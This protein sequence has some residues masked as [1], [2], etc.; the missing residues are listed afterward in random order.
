MRNLSVEDLSQHIEL[1]RP[2]PGF[3]YQITKSDVKTLVALDFPASWM[4]EID[5]PEFGKIIPTDHLLATIDEDYRNVGW[6][7]GE[8][9]SYKNDSYAGLICCYSCY[10]TLSSVIDLIPEEAQFSFFTVESDHPD[11]IT[12]GTVRIYLTLD[13][14]NAMSAEQF[15]AIR[16]LQG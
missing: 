15:K 3:P 8:K 2:V 9:L 11:D 6:I 10:S 5:Q 12:T 13:Q 4:V 1:D 7:G 16:D 14:I